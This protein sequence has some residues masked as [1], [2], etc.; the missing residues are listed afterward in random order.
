M[1]AT[2]V[3]ETEQARVSVSLQANTIAETV[4]VRLFIIDK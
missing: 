3:Y 4:T 1:M 2:L